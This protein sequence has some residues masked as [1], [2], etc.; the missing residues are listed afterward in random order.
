MAM[1]HIAC[2]QCPAAARLSCLAVLLLCSSLLANTKPLLLSVHSVPSDYV[3]RLSSCSKA[4]ASQSFELL[5]L[6]TQE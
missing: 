2:A 1:A 4:G 5:A 6:A 3:Q